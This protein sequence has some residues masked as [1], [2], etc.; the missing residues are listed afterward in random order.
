MPVLS[1]I[2]KM[3]PAIPSEFIS[4]VSGLEKIIFTYARVRVVIRVTGVA[5]LNRSVAR[6]LNET[7]NMNGTIATFRDMLKKALTGSLTDLEGNVLNITGKDF[8]F[9]LPN[10][11]IADGRVA[12]KNAQWS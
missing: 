4:D 5:Q 12:I 8:A 2:K 7:L 6:S 9:I 10:G 3:R 1:T 11:S